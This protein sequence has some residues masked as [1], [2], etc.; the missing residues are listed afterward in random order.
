MFCAAIDLLWV[1]PLGFWVMTLYFPLGIQAAAHFSCS[2]VN[3]KLPLL[4][5]KLNSD[6][7]Q[8]NR[9]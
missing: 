4:T 1:H 3:L 9:G 2:N 5:N 8:G 7:H 6:S